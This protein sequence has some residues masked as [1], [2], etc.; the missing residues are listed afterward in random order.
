MLGDYAV[1]MGNTGGD[2]RVEFGTRLEHSIWYESPKIGGVFSFDALVSPG[3][4]RT[5]NNRR[6]I[7]GLAGLQR[8]Q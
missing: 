3:Q 8:R 2:N 7:I 6:S 1:V 5:Y 4:N